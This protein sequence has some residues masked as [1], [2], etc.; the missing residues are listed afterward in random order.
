[1]L[2]IGTDPMTLTQDQ[3]V[4]Y[5]KQ[6]QKTVLFWQCAV[7][8]QRGMTRDELLVFLQKPPKD[9]RW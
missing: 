4:K 3:L 2:K 7:A 9:W 1:M 5:V 6:L 8:Q